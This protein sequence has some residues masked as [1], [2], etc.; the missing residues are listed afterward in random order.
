MFN[1]IPEACMSF[2]KKSFL[3][4]G[5]LLVFVFSA[6]QAFSCPMGTAK[7]FQLS[8][9]SELFKGKYDGKLSIGEL[10]KHG[11]FGIGT[12]QGMDGEMVVVDGVVYQ[13]EISGNATPAPDKMKTPFA[14]VTF[15]TPDQKFRVGKI[16]S[17]KELQT[18]VEA[19]LTDKE[20]VY[21]VRIYNGKF[22]H[23]RLRSISKQKK[24]YPVLT[25]VIK[26]QNAFILE[27]E[28][29]TLV[30]F[31]APEKLKDTLVPGLHLHGL[32]TG[33]K[34]GGHVLDLSF[35]GNDVE[36]EKITLCHDSE[37]CSKTCPRGEHSQSSEKHPK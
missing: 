23:L 25:E 11:D 14:S 6:T 34:V 4:L 5:L 35:L 36:I 29:A 33:K 22:D 31:W 10:K 18:A 2:L 12:F 20:A 15:F 7:L 27:K 9:Y 1:K 13:V 32:L 26:R 19:H 16:K 28:E 21:A 30:G 3:S 24:P 37:K 17:M 8:T